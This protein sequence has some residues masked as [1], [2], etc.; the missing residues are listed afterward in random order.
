MAGVQLKT[1]LATVIVSLASLVPAAVAIGRYRHRALGEDRARIDPLVDEVHGHAGHRDAVRQGLADRVE[2]GKGRQQ[3]GVHVDDPPRE[4][5]HEAGRKQLHVA[6]E[7]DQVGLE[8]LQP[9]GHRLVALLATLIGVARE[10]GGWDRR[11]RGA[12]ERPRLR[13]VGADAHELD[14]LAAVHVVDQRLQVGAAAR[15]EDGGAKAI[16]GGHRQIRRRGARAR[17][18]GTCRRS[19]AGAP[20]Q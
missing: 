10:H 20:P 7:H 17:A 18:S 14:P 3:R 11:L 6:G 8:P 15:G 13:L 16:V 9:L 2:A 19:S 1:L 12:L 4:A 5:A